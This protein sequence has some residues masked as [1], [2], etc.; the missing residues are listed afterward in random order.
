SGQLGDG[1]TANKSVPTLIYQNI[2]DKIIVGLHLGGD[3][4]AVIFNVEVLKILGLEY[5]IV[6]KRYGHCEYNIYDEETNFHYCSKDSANFK[7]S[8]CNSNCP[9]FK[10]NKLLLKDE[11]KPG[12]NTDLIPVKSLSSKTNIVEGISSL[13]VRGAV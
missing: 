12:E 4:S 11:F 9:F 13:I 6:S 5:P 7:T 1:T 2:G 3:S 8:N 10:Q